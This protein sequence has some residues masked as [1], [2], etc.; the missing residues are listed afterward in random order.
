[1]ITELTSADLG[2]LFHRLTMGTHWLR[3]QKALSWRKRN[4]KRAGNARVQSRDECAT[5]EATLK[6]VQPVQ[7][8]MGISGW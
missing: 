8:T 1:M 3:P 2:A 7:T 5:T 6:T 4:K